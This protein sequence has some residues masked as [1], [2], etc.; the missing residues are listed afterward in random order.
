MRWTGPTAN[1]LKF[2]LRAGGDRCPQGQCV[3]SSWVLI[4]TSLRQPW[5]LPTPLQLGLKLPNCSLIHL[6]EAFTPSKCLFHPRGDSSASTQI[7]VHLPATHRHPPTIHTQGFS[8][9]VGVG[10]RWSWPK[11]ET[12]EV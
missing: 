3:S 10:W 6:W 4:P 5:A 1:L 2:P 7:G 9:W 11:H 12:G 8:D